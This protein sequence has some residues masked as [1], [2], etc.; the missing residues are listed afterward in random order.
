[1]SLRNVGDEKRLSTAGLFSI[2]TE[3]EEELDV[4]EEPM[5][6]RRKKMEGR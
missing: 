3:E 1:M 4:K 2:L 5:K 6:K